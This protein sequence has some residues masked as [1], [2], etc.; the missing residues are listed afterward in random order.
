MPTTPMSSALTRIPCN[1]A[2]YHG[3]NIN[4][5]YQSA[6]HAHYTSG[7]TG[8]ADRGLNHS[9]GGVMSP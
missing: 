8:G 4:S 5:G 1:L 6:D 3:V 2:H 7:T 9:H